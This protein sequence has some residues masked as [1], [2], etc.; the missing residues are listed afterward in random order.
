[1]R[2]VNDVIVETWPRLQMPRDRS[3]LYDVTWSRA[4]RNGLGVFKLNVSGPLRFGTGGLISY[5]PWTI[6]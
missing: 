1:M 4:M 6:L 5:V 3:L 2:I